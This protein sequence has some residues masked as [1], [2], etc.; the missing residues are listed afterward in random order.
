M[1]KIGGDDESAANLAV[2]WVPSGYAYLRLS[3]VS[4]CVH[5]PA[6]AAGCQSV[7][8]GDLPQTGT[9]RPD[10][11]LGPPQPACYYGAWR[12]SSH[13]WCGAARQRPASCKRSTSLRNWSCRKGLRLDRRGRC[14]EEFLAG[15]YILLTRGESA[16]LGGAKRAI[17][18]KRVRT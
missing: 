9:T 12:Q 18:A 2:V 11:R 13:V 17:S 3:E 14:R 8:S 6:D 15:R 5:E 7:A 16:A 4:W 10:S 1:A